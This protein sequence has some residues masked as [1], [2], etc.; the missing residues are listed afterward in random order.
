MRLT[1]LGT[2]CPQCDDERF[3]PASLVTTPCGRSYL[4]DC[5]SGVTQRLV[6]AGMPGRDLD[7]VL[8]THLHSDHLVDLFQL[9]VSSWHQ[10]RARPQRVFGPAGTR[11]F[12]DGTM[13]VWRAELEL[14][15]AHERRPSTAA[16]EVEVIEFEPGVVLDEG[17]LIVEAVEVDHRPVVPAYGFV[18]RTGGRTLAFSG[19]T[20]YCPALIEAARGADMLVHEV[21][22]H[23]ELARA[24]PA[25]LS[26]E[27]L[28]AVAGYHT[29]SSEVGKV[30][31]EAG[32]KCLVLNHFVPVRFDKEALLAEVRRDFGGGGSGGDRRPVVIGEDLMSLD[33][34][35]G[36]LRYRGAL[37]ALGDGG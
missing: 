20:R 2:G 31:A 30:A 22:I 14:R 13:A 37:L 35:T 8:V 27:G 18:F 3:G 11:A 4:I 1:L 7:A 6:A 25:R 9:I 34:A 32:V 12:V 33:L 36:A 19:D 21:F 10:G 28:R 17:G 24:V 5:G 29:L 16:P 26:E 23:R 15:I